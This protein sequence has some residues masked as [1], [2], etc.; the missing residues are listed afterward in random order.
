ME[1]GQNQ[2]EFLN[3]DEAHK[4]LGISKSTLQ[5]MC[6]KRIITFYKPNGKL[7]FFKKSD[8]IKFLEDGR[9]PSIEEE[10]KSIGRFNQ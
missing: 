3:T 4:F 8:L 7:V 2:L 10:Y 6:H 5:K 1:K 9:V